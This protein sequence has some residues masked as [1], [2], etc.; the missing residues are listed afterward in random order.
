MSFL[1]PTGNEELRTRL[2]ILA[3]LGFFA[4]T[5]RTLVYVENPL[6]YMRH[7]LWAI[8]AVYSPVGFGLVTL[9]ETRKEREKKTCHLALLV[10]N[11]YQEEKPS[12][13]RV[14]IRPR[15]ARKTI[16]YILSTRRGTRFR[17]A[18]SKKPT[19]ARQLE[20]KARAQNKIGFEVVLLNF[21][22]LQ[23]ARSTH[24]RGHDLTCEWLSWPDANVYIVWMNVAIA[25]VGLRWLPRLMSWIVVP[26]GYY[27]PPRNNNIEYETPFLP[28]KVYKNCPCIDFSQ[29]TQW[30]NQSNPRRP[31]S[32]WWHLKYHLAQKKKDLR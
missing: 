15:T 2:N 9:H 6:A 3:E 19:G 1:P 27:L 25:S 8:R 4:Q 11:H 29:S 20:G 5:P 31:S 26:L 17:K 32:E 21:V 23:V 28:Q 10:A 30:T 18:T 22:V 16:G 12:S 7:I 24:A 13:T 14:R